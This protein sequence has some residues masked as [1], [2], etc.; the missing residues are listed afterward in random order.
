VQLLGVVG[1]DVVL[2][3]SGVVGADVVLAGSGVVGADVVLGDSGVVGADVVLGDLGV[4]GAV[5][6][7]GDHGI[8]GAGVVLGDL[9]KR[10]VAVTARAARKTSRAAPQ[11]IT[12]A[13]VGQRRSGELG[14]GCKSL[15]ILSYLGIWKQ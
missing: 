6:V 13:M 8:V 15:L 7:L 9:V 3:D 11:R 2:A 12:S 4:V 10:A 5:V 1:A 14:V